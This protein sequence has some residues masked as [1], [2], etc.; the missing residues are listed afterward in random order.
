MN[1][2]SRSILAVTTALAMM[3]GFSMTATA[4]PSPI[5]NPV[6][7]SLETGGFVTTAPVLSP[8]GPVEVTPMFSVGVGKKFYIYLTPLEQKMLIGGGSVAL[9]AAVCAST[10]VVGCATISF[11]IGAAAVY[12]NERGVCKNR[13]EIAIGLTNSYKCV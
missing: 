9:V 11:A 12:L 1:K 7:V 4:A 3:L 10:G 13:F 2:L 6:V 8:G 5:P